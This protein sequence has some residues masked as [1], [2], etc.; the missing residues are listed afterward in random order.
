[1]DV[2]DERSVSVFD[3]GNVHTCAV[4][5]NLTLKCCGRNQFGQLGD[6][7]TSNRYT[8]TPIDV[9]DETRVISIAL[10]GDHTCAILDNAL[11][12]CWGS[13]AR[14]Q[15]GDSTTT[16]SSTPTTL[17]ILVSIDRQYPLPLVVLVQTMVGH[18]PV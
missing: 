15:L 14:G 3:L 16:N 8:P 1:M 7:T 9:G 4:L 6:S 10:G 11:L 17:L 2:G 12:K 13:N 18:I 5:D